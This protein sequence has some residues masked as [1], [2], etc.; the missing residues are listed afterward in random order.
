MTG[1]PSMLSNIGDSIDPVMKLVTAAAYLIGFWLIWMSISKLSKMADH[2][3]RSSSQG[4]LFIPAAFFMGGAV[5]LFL[6]SY[7]E[8]AQNTFFGANAPMAYTN[9]LS[10]LIDKYSSPMYVI[11]KLVQ[12]AGVIWFI[13]GV[14]LLVYAS[15]PGAKVGSKGLI[16]VIAGI[17]AMNLN[18][19]INLISYILNAIAVMTV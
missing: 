1:I 17:F 5:L 9:W 11:T 6:P 14:A 3:A 4:K 12:L 15:E 2:R 18:N 16:F 10:S 7:V 19:T 13:R 8:V